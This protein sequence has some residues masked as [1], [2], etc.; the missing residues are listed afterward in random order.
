MTYVLSSIAHI[1]L[2]FFVLNCA[3]FPIDYKY[4]A[5]SQLTAYIKMLL[6]FKYFKESLKYLGH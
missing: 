6:K 5:V 4:Y 3:N 1:K 2:A